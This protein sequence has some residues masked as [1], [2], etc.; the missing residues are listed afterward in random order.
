ME[1]ELAILNTGEPTFTTN[2]GHYSHLDLTLVD[3][4]LAARFSWTV[5]PQLYHSGHFPIIISSELP[6]DPKVI[7]QKWLL[8]KADWGAYQAALKLP[9]GY[10]T[11]SMAC[12]EVVGR[13][14]AA[15]LESI[16]RTTGKVNRAVTHSWWTPSCSAAQKNKHTEYNRYKRHEGNLQ[17]YIEYK[18]A[19]AGLR[20]TL[21][22]AKR[23]SWV[24]FV[25]SIKVSTLAREVWEKVRK[26][27]GSPKKNNSP[28]SSQNRQVADPF[29]RDFATRGS[30]PS[31]QE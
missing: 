24:N 19:R 7:N 30:L 9:T 1:N 16:P 31:E 10:S 25:S 6:P 5:H 18:K 4:G 17:L 11:L 8:A 23:V 26:L 29:A 13:L 15:A 14:E 20:H 3:S 22:A 12:S 28:D 2:K 27:R 21:L